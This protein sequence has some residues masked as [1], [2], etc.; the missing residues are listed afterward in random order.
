MK[1]QFKLLACLLV[2][3]AM[4]F[5][6]ASCDLIDKIFGRDKHVHN[7][8]DGE[9]DCGEADPDYEAP[10]EHEFV[11]G[12]CGCGEEDPDYVPEPT[13]YTV[14]LLNKAGWAEVAVYYWNNGNEVSWP[15]TLITVGEDGLYKAEIDSACGNLIFNNNNAGAQTVDLVAPT[16][17]NIVYDNVAKAWMT[18]AEAIEALSAAP[19]EGVINVTTTDT[20]TWDEDEYTF[21]A[22]EKGNY[23][24]TV[25]AG[26]GVYSQTAKDN[27]AE[28]EVDYYYNYT[29]AEFTV[30]L[31]KDASFVFYVASTQVGEW[32]ITWTMSEYVAPPKDVDISL[33]QNTVSFT[34]EDYKSGAEGIIEVSEEAVYTVVG[35]GLHIVI[36]TSYGQILVEGDNSVTV[37]LSGWS[38][39]PSV[40]Y[41]KVTPA[42]AGNYSFAV[43]ANI[44]V[45]LSTGDNTIT[46]DESLESVDGKFYV[47]N[48]GLYTFVGEGL[49]FD[50]YEEDEKIGDNTA[51]V[52]LESYTEYTL[53]IRATAA[54]EYTLTISAPEYLTT[55]ENSVSVEGTLS[56]YFQGTEEATYS[57]TGEGLTIVIKDTDGNVV[58]ASAVESYTTYVVEITAAEAGDYTLY[59]GLT[60]AVGHQKNPEKLETS[61]TVAHPGNYSMYYLEFTAAVTGHAT[62]TWTPDDII[63][64]SS[65]MLDGNYYSGV[66]TVTIPVFAGTTYEVGVSAY[67][68]GSIIMALS[69]EEG[70]LT[71]SDYKS[72]LNGDTFNLATGLTAWLYYDEY[73]TKE[74]LINIYNSTYSID[75]YYTYTVTVNADGTLTLTPTLC[76][77]KE[78]AGEAEFGE[79]E[80]TFV[81]GDFN[82]FYHVDT[83]SDG[84][85]N[86]GC[87]KYLL[88]KAGQAFK[89]QMYQASLDKTLYFTGAMNGYYFATSENV[90]DGVDVYVE[91]ADG[92][93]NMY[94]MSGETKNY[95]YAIASGTYT[96][97]K[98]GTSNDGNL[99]SFNEELGTLVTV[100]NGTDYYLGTY[101]TY[102]T[103]SASKTSFIDSTNVDVSQFVARPVVVA[104]AE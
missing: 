34:D 26:L 14:Y 93:F 79:I 5:T 77:D 12:K 82:Y 22:S 86:C 84:K 66:T 8:V 101:G 69:V 33:G 27:Y 75:L 94:F 100:V 38:W 96:N 23:T 104:E 31:E 65:V 60:Y 2:V 70:E 88:P 78:N 89:L 48:Y 20:Y 103:I 54:G 6:L 11:D 76:A 10:H 13:T 3:I 64:L 32:T 99:W 44:P 39:Y 95:I 56:V 36:S 49:T 45:E 81:D 28:A 63:G 29:G 15:G 37:T 83:N 51:P 57:F 55:G 67:E 91:E 74:Y 18:Y 73:G 87:G 85:C 50:I 68:A 24:F 9:C 92:G 58:E 80:V 52:V 46:I 1:R 43:S 72:M 16:D 59:I 41:I 40:Y 97:V 90:D 98:F 71:E 4:V 47:V 17:D 35:E 42:A 102:T 61:T 7:Y 25:P 30:A 21:V 62:L 53:V 19:T